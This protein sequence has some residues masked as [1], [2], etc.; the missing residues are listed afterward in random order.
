M[1]WETIDYLGLVGGLLLLFSFWRINSG[2]WKTTSLWYELDN[3]IACLLLVVYAW[4]KHAY[5]NILLNIVWGIVAFKG[6]SSLAERRMRAN[7]AFR[8]GYT[9]GTRFRKSFSSRSIR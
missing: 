2:K 9:K 3:V 5:V 7:P 8:K 1:S 4:E 6:L